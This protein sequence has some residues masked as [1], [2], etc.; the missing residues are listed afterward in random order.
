MGQLALSATKDR[1]LL[2]TTAHLGNPLRN[3][4]CPTAG[5]SIYPGIIYQVEQAPFPTAHEGPER[6][7]LTQVLEIL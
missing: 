1:C 2:E 4:N 7:P 3:K 6:Q 5:N